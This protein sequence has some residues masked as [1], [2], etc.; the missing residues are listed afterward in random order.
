MGRAGIEPATL[1]ST[2]RR[3]PA[4]FGAAIRSRFQSPVGHAFSVRGRDGTLENVALPVRGSARQSSPQ[5]GGFDRIGA[6][7]AT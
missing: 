7:E 4:A 1:G 3:R 6:E 2:E 5:S